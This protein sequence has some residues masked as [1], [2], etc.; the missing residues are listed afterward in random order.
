MVSTTRW[1]ERAT[2]SL[3]LLHSVLLSCA[4]ER[5]PDDPTPIACNVA[6]QA[7]YT[8]SRMYCDITKVRQHTVPWT[9]LLEIGTVVLM[10]FLNKQ[11]VNPYLIG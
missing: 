5:A 2:L 11:S 4:K 7:Y 3:A 6:G 1:A 10:S 9:Q 8:S